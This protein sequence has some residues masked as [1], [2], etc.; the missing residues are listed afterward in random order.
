MNAFWKRRLWREP[1]GGNLHVRFDEGE[2]S[3]VIG[4]QTFH[5][6]LSS[7]LYG[8]PWFRPQTF[9]VLKRVDKCVQFA[10]L[11]SHP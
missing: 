10:V 4:Q 5:P 8:H 3:A 9:A 1:D 11:N 2:G 7:L 6:V